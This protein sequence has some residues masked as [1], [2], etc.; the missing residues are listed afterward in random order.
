MILM[1]GFIGVS[2]LP[3]FP[4]ATYPTPPTLPTSSLGLVQVRNSSLP[5]DPNLIPKRATQL[6]DQ[7]MA[8]HPFDPE[9]SQVPFQEKH[10]VD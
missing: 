4:R 8:T 9:Y 3:P 1:P 7:W 2:A 5:T 6:M 10:T